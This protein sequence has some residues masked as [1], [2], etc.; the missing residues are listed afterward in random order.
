MLDLSLSMLGWAGY[1]KF[2]LGASLRMLGL[3]VPVIIHI[4]HIRSVNFT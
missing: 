4:F 3:G 2:N 1:R